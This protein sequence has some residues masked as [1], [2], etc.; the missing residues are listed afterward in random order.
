MPQRQCPVFVCCWMAHWSLNGARSIG[1]V[2]Y[3]G[4][5]EVQQSLRALI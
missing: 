4:V 5:P 1:S 3:L 2:A